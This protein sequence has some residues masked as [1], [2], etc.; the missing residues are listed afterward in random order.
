MTTRVV[1]LGRMCTFPVLWRVTCSVGGFTA[2]TESAPQAL[3]CMVGATSEIAERA[4]STFFSVLPL[5]PS[6][7]EQT[8]LSTVVCYIR[9]Q[10]TL[11][12]YN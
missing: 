3:V 5:G 11:S 10:L 7:W 8:S 12:G 9:R 4:H 1:A 2:R 6:L